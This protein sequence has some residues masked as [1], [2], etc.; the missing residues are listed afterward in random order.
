MKLPETFVSGKDLEEKTQELTKERELKKIGDVPE[1]I[2]TLEDALKYVLNSVVTVYGY[3]D[4]KRI[5]PVELTIKEAIKNR[6]SFRGLFLSDTN[7]LSYKGL[8]FNEDRAV[9]NIALEISLNLK[10]SLEYNITKAGIDRIISFVNAKKTRKW[11]LLGIYNQ[12]VGVG[13]YVKVNVKTSPEILW[14]F[15]AFKDFKPVIHGGALRDLYLGIPRTGDVDV[16]V[17]PDGHKGEKE[18]HKLF[19]KIMDEVELAQRGRIQRS[20]YSD[21][22][23]PSQYRGKKNKVVYDIAGG[24]FPRYLSIEN[25]KMETPDELIIH[26]LTKNDLDN[27]QFRMIDSYNVPSRIIAKISKLQSLGLKFLDEDPSDLS[28]KVDAASLSEK[29]RATRS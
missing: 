12:Q 22:H 1:N 13:Q 20:Y 14:I 26:D 28:S 17:S 27:K 29:K 9:D 15:E 8:Y 25:L 11:S 19:C 24:T 7:P 2:K 23:T 4:K 21:D 18:L 10:D 16:Q 5:H 6:I 3:D